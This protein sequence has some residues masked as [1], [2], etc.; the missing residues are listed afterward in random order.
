MLCAVLDVAHFQM[1][2]CLCLILLLLAPTMVMSELYTDAL[3]KGLLFFEAQRSGKLPGDNRVPW[4]GDSCL[5]DGSDVGVD[6]S[7]AYFDS[8]DHIVFGLPMSFTVTMMAYGL[9]EYGELY[10]EA[11]DRAVEALKWGTDW[12]L[13]AHASPNELYVQVGDG[14]SDHACWMRPEDLTMARPSFK[15]N[16][17][18]PGSDVAAEA[19]AAMA[20]ASIVFQESD[21]GYHDALILHATQLFQFADQ[22]R[23]TYSDSVP[24]AAQF[25]K[26][27]SGYGDELLW[28]AAWLHRATAD[29]SYITYM[30][31]SNSNDGQLNWKGTASELSWDDKR[32]AAHVLIA[33]L[34]LLGQ[35]RS[36]TILD[37]YKKAADSFVCTYVTGSTPK[38]AAGLPW[39]REWSPLQY[40]TTSAF[41]IAVYG[42]VLRQSGGSLT[43]AGTVYTSDMLLDYSRRQAD[44][45]FGANPRNMSY[46]VGVS[47]SFPQR[48]H[49][50]AASIPP[51]G[52]KYACGEGFRFFQTSAANPNV[53]NGAIVGGPD[54]GDRYQDAR[55]NFQQSEPSTYT[56]APFLGLLARLRGAPTGQPIS[57]TTGPSSAPR[58]S[59]PLSTPAPSNTFGP[60]SPPGP[61][62]TPGPTS[63]V[64]SLSCKCICDGF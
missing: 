4:R 3:S 55:T 12:L 45:I 29:A 43:C 46:M 54:Q 27:Y 52:S 61:S 35:Q 13:R 28:A 22:H 19:A 2:N 32:A 51:D 18:K 48:V 5:S 8:G 64:E 49:H 14:Q 39:V 30:T 37:E 10:G 58:P 15:I 1:A 25:Y 11:H 53:I 44:Y 38:T 7:R 31:G 42:D 20:A 57:S 59:S 6:L 17:S 63:S 56:V 40:V 50:R 62:N 24:E 9:V 60:S 34:V 47:E 36:G 23:G 21:P 16:P 33:R 26:S 41:V